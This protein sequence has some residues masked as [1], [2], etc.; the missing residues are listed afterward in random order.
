MIAFLLSAI[1]FSIPMMHLLLLREIFPV[2]SASDFMFGI[3]FAHIVLSAFLG[4]VFGSKFT[5]DNLRKNLLFCIAALCAAFLFSFFYARGIRYFLDIPLGRL[6]TLKNAFLYCFLIIFPTSFFSGLLIFLSKSW[7]EKFG[8]S[9]QK[10]PLNLYFYFFAG[11]SLIFYSLILFSVNGFGIVLFICLILSVIFLAIAKSAKAQCVFLLFII[12]FFMSHPLEF[13]STADKNIL[14]KNFSGYIIKNY[15]YSSYGQNVLVNKNKEWTLLTNHIIN[16]S[17]PDDEIVYSQDFAHMSILHHQN[18]KNI[19]IISGGPKIL[20][21]IL[22][23]NIA[24]IDYI[25]PDKTVLSIIENDIIKDS[26]DDKRIHFYGGNVRKFL[27]DKKYDLIFIGIPQ[28]SNLALNDYYTKE[29]FLKTK[30]ALSPGGFVSLRLPGYESY[31]LFLTLQLNASIDKS[32]RSAYDFVH[33]IPGQK[34]IIIASKSEMPPRMQ[35]KKRLEKIQNN[36]LLLSNRYLDDRMD[37]YKTAWLKN[38]LNK[39]VNEN[40][41]NS[42]WSPE[43]M[44]FDFMHLHSDLSPRVSI[45]LEQTKRYLYFILLIPIILCFV[46]RDIHKE[47]S[48]V[49]GISTAGLSMISIFAVQIYTQQ[50]IKFLGIIIALFFVGVFISKFAK[51]FSFENKFSN[52]KM[53]LI[54]ICNIVLII[55]WIAVFEFSLVIL[56]VLFIFTLLT[57]FLSGLEM[58]NL[59]INWRNSLF[60]LSKSKVIIFYFLAGLWLSLLFGGG[61]FILAAG[62]QKSLLLILLFRFILFCRWADLSKRRLL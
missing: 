42:D 33:I 4:Y 31:R 30:E 26:L 56:P 45:I 17:F 10:Y 36:T 7:A 6:I 9:N 48:F 41:E 59:L 39:N 12:V 50:I 5:S 19:L 43:G 28:P 27:K 61:Y 34:N 24:S 18:P 14:S 3:I 2:F 55:M 21:E 58:T 44:I 16:F 13:I 32:L 1:G 22:K 38:E 20:S 25:E 46:L 37:A 53:F 51:K 52:E 57:G 62:F 35:I 15:K 60:N 8:K 47:T 40:M 29:F 11:L 54:E 49:C 23:Y